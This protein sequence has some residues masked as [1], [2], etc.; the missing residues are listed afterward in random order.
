MTADHRAGEAL[1]HLQRA[2]LEMIQAARST[3]DLVEDVVA[4]PQSLAAVVAQAGHLVQAVVAAAAAARL[5]P[6]PAQAPTPVPAAGRRQPAGPGQRPPR[7]RLG[8]RAAHPR[9]SDRRPSIAWPCC[10]ACRH[11]HL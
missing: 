2:A 4:D 3:L 8:G 1:E 9:R 10:V 7:R 11:V 6:K 5:A